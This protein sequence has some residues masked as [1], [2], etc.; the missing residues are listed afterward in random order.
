MGM[1]GDALP[2]PEQTKQNDEELGEHQ[3]KKTGDVF[4]QEIMAMDAEVEQA[5]EP[6]D[7]IDFCIELQYAFVAPAFAPDG[8]ATQDITQGSIAAEGNDEQRR[9]IHKGK[10]EQQHSH[11]EP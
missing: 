10:Q 4:P 5:G 6:E 2:E 3:D 8:N 11:Q 7:G 9:K 1:E